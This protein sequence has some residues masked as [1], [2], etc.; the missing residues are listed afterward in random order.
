M[1]NCFSIFGL[2]NHMLSTTFFCSNQMPGRESTVALAALKGHTKQLPRAGTS[3]SFIFS[4]LL[5]GPNKWQQQCMVFETKIINSF[6]LEALPILGTT[7]LWLQSEANFQLRLEHIILDY[8]SKRDLDT[9]L[10]QCNRS[11]RYKLCP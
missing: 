8:E 1:D 4:E 3:P 11:C 9:L 10:G 2:K 7:C 6:S 5:T